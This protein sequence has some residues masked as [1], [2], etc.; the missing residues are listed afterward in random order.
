MLIEL[1]LVLFWYTYVCLVYLLCFH[2]GLL[3]INCLFILSV[4]LIKF[5]DRA[6]V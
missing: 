1:L 3:V 4:Y 2:I 5:I 6:Q